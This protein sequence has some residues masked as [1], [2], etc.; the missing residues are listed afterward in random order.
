MNTNHSNG[1]VPHIYCAV[2]KTYD[3]NGDDDEHS[4]AERKIAK[5]FS[6]NALLGH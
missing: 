2:M 6:N 3:K 1:D 4:S 5:M